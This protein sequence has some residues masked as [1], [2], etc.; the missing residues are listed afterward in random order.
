[1][2]VD[3]IDRVEQLVTLPQVVNQINHIVESTTSSAADLHRVIKADPALS[4]KLLRLVNSAYYGLAERVGSLERAVILLGVT[5]V[6]NLAIAASIDQVFR[7]ISLPGPLSGRDLWIH[8]LG[9]ASGARAL[10]QRAKME[11]MDEVF[12]AGLIHDV[13]LLAAAQVSPKDFAQVI[14]ACMGSN[15]RWTVAEREILGIDHSTSGARLTKRWHFPDCMVQ[16]VADHHNWPDL[17][18]SS[19]LAGIVY[20]ADT[21]AC[22]M[23][24]GF[25]LTANHQTIEAEMLTKLGL[26]QQDVTEVWQNVPAYVE[27]LAACLGV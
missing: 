3:Q 1:M 9:V 6:K 20:V 16:T 5:A 17:P 13:G 25:S 12:T 27:E 10:A 22:G 7:R 26:C 8:C 21:M 11:H 19:N 4:S 15:N 23:G 2:F 24:D 14:Q 18:G